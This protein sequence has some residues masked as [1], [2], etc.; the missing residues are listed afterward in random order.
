MRFWIG[1]LI[2]FYYGSNN[3]QYILPVIAVLLI[4]SSLYDKHIK[5]KST[6]SIRCE[7]EEYISKH[8]SDIKDSLSY[9]EKVDIFKR[10]IVCLSRIDPDKKSKI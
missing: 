8:Y 6:Y 4:S 1:V 9:D 2:L 7:V 5:L 3:P 10:D